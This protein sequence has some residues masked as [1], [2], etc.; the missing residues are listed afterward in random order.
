MILTLKRPRSDNNTS[1]VALYNTQHS[2]FGRA[3]DLYKTQLSKIFRNFKSVKN[4]DIDQGGDG[5]PFTSI[6]PT[7]KII[8]NFL[9]KNCGKVHLNEGKGA[10]F[11]SITPSLPIFAPMTCYNTQDSK[12]RAKNTL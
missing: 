12:K 10:P 9:L 2:F 4:R 6:T 5:A 3:M 11:T 1:Q 7:Y 8:G